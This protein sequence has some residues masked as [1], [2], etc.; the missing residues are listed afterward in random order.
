M[1]SRILSLLLALLVVFS[2]LP[3]FAASD[4]EEPEEQ[5]EELITADI[6][7][8]VLQAGGMPVRAEKKRG[9]RGNLAA[10]IAAVADGISRRETSIY[11]EEFAVP[12]SEVGTCYGCAVNSHPEFFYV[13]TAYRYL[14]SNDGIHV[15]L[16]KPSY[17]E[18]YDEEDTA[19][20][21]GVCEAILAELPD[22][23]AE[24]KYLYIHDYIVTHCQ[25]DLTYSKF[26]AFQCLV[27][28]SAVC[29]GYALAFLHLCNL[30][31]LDA[32]VISSNSLEHSWNAVAIDGEH[33]Y[34]DCTWEERY[35]NVNGVNRQ[36]IPS[37]CHHNHFLGSWQDCR[38]THDSTDWVNNMGEDVYNGYTSTDTYCT[39]WWTGLRD[40]VLR[41]VQWIG[42]QMYYTMTNDSRHIYRI[43]SGLTGK[44]TIEIRNPPAIWYVFNDSSS[45]YPSSYIT[46][47]ALNG[48]IYYSTPTE[49]WKIAAD[50]SF[51]RIYT[52]TAGE[53]AKGYIYGIQAIGGSLVYHLTTISS[54][55]STGGGTL[56]VSDLPELFTVVF[57]GN[58]G[59]GKMAVQSA[60]ANTTVT[61]VSNVFTRED[62]VFSGWNTEYDGSGVAYG[63]G[64]DVTLTSD[65]TLYA[66]WTPYVPEYIDSGECGADGD[67]LTWTLDNNLVLSVFGSGAMAS[68]PSSDAFPWAAYRGFITGAVI[69]EGVTS[70]SDHAFRDCC[71]MTSIT[72]PESVTSIGKMAFYFCSDLI[73][74]AIPESVTSIGDHAFYCCRSLQNAAIPEG[75]T[76]IGDGVFFY[77]DS[78][79]TITI[80]KSVTDIGEDAFYGCESLSSVFFGGSEAEWADVRIQS[81][82]DPLDGADLYCNLESVRGTFTVSFDGNG[83]SGTMK[84]QIMPADTPAALRRNAF[85]RSGYVFSG[86]NTAPG[87][88]GTAYA[89]GAKIT[90]GAD[91]TLYAQ[92]ERTAAQIQSV[93]NVSV[94]GVPACR[95]MINCDADAG[96]TAFAARYDASGRFLGVETMLL[97]QGANEFT[98]L[99]QGA[100]EVRFFLLTKG[101]WAPISGVAYAAFSQG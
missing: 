32:D 57:D 47:A 51:H 25:Y 12:L 70:I 54:N 31:G 3:V 98:V 82:N 91:L 56:N 20:F 67:S 94:S 1:K 28:G 88:S 68:Y 52:L 18:N 33:Y 42:D 99:F 44:T 58:G 17:N 22:G 89:A 75:M 77:C 72:L 5:T 86:W 79:K 14:P 80:P 90:S 49:I 16:I 15:E 9:D 55:P 10:A 38:D 85:T 84:V 50:G 23:T 46:A 2:L 24:E 63:D 53:L 87:G 43:D 74:V 97:L 19:R 8:L 30:A 65:L 66:Q 34:I 69:G 101:T 29:E 78:M 83:G 13:G 93:E 95:A 40:Y 64:S 81:G 92:W 96:V 100:E 76:S 71:D 37:Y 39:E 26:N 41:P 48:E 60:P 4:G 62:Y 27:E 59:E 21:A 11:I 35:S 36:L 7:D 45:H 61:L 73:S 6:S